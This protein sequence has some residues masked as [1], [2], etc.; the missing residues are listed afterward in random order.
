MAEGGEEL[1]KGAVQD[2]MEVMARWS[3]LS[4]ARERWGRDMTFVRS[5]VTSCARSGNLCRAVAM[6]WIWVMSW[7]VDLDIMGMTRLLELWMDQC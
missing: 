5:T 1:E 3:G 6:A 2:R 7:R 4:S